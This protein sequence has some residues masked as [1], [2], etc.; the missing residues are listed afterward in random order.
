[1]SDK[2]LGG[3]K[4]TLVVSATLCCASMATHGDWVE[5]P[6][7]RANPQ[8]QEAYF[9]WSVALEDGI[10]VI[11]AREDSSH[12]DRAGAAFAF[13][14]DGEHWVQTQRMLPD[15]VAAGDGFGVDVALEGEWLVVGAYEDDDVGTDAGAAYVFRN[16]QGQW[17]LFQKL[18]PWDGG[19]SLSY[20]GEAVAIS[21]NH[22][23]AGAFNH[24]SSDAL[25]AV[26]VFKFDGA[27]WMPD[28]VLPNPD[29]AEPDNFGRALA[30]DGQWLIVGAQHDA[31]LSPKAGAAY[32]YNFSNDG[33][34]LTAE[35]FPEDDVP[36]SWFGHSVAVDASRLVVGAPGDSDDTPESGRVYVYEYDGVAWQNVSSISSPGPDGDQFAFG[37]S[38][39]DTRLA[40]G[41]YRDGVQGFRSGA[42]YI[43]DLSGPSW[44]LAGTLRPDDGAP[45]DRFGIS[46]A[47]DGRYVLVGAHQ[48]DDFLP[49]CGDA[50]V[51]SEPNTAPICEMDLSDAEERFYQPA[52][53]EFVVT[54]GETI[55]AIVTGT[56]PDGDDLIAELFDLPSEATL[57]PMVGPSPLTAVMEWTPHPSD[58]VDAP[59]YPQVIFTDSGNLSSDAD[60]CWFTIVDINLPPVAIC[61]DDIVVEADGPDGT[62][63]MLVGSGTDEDDDDAS[64]MY[65]WDTSVALDDPDSTT[66]T[67]LFPIGSTQVFLTVADG[68]GGHD[69][70]FFYVTV[71]DTTPPEVICTTDVA[72]LWPPKHDMCEVTVKLSATDACQDPDF[73]F[74]LLSA[75]VSSDELDDAIG[76][77]DG[78]T[79]GDVDGW[80]GHTVPASIYDR[81][82][83]DA[84]EQAYIGTIELRAE[85]AGDGDG[86]KYTI[87]FIVEDS[88]HNLATATCCVIVP[89]DRRGGH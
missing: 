50:F 24:T 28:Q 46:V 32:V 66:P 31:T 69:E 62:Y 65:H 81:L 26:Y 48:D 5:W 59:Y 38:L 37:V 56:D 79:T 25:G 17:E 78:E 27:Q 47:L 7:L 64:L 54:A 43:Y 73:V 84:D 23:V 52:P 9:G 45:L 13:A 83:W 39:D 74:P 21:G 36:T 34:T 86:R 40:V 61:P 57:T 29:G 6:Q 35:L 89:H 44:V 1:M 4:V 16:C 82:S 33:W 85:R 18:L 53:G 11:G 2:L 77:G 8:Q 70:C 14:I 19:G 87:E 72:V 42:A 88:S 63:V 75:T 15:D 41:A 68:R 71:Q 67:G 49:N 76:D 12:G 51:F 60:V 3:A 10:A 22:L 30:L 20:F 55:M 80:D 58:K